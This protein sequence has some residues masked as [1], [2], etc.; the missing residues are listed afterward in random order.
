M[1][2][3]LFDLSGI[4]LNIYNSKPSVCLNDAIDQQQKTSPALKHFTIEEFIGRTVAYF[5]RWSLLLSQANILK[6]TIAVQQFYQIYE[7]LWMHQSVKRV[8][9]LS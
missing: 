3:I 4:G 9:V 2:L 7:S 6:A 1:K 8:V 5:Q